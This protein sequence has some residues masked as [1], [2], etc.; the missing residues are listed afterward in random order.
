MAGVRLAPHPKRIIKIQRVVSKNVQ[1]VR[2][3]CHSM[4]RHEKEDAMTAR[5][6]ERFATGLTKLV[7]GLVTLRGE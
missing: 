6:M 4:K 2:L 3:Y 5:F 7:A 1:E